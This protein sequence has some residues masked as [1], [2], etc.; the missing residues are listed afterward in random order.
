MAT[1]RG[2]KEDQRSPTAVPEHE[3]LE[4]AA[5]VGSPPTDVTFVH[6]SVRSR[7]DRG[8]L[9]PKARAIQRQTR[10]DCSTSP[11][12]NAMRFAFHAADDTHGKHP[13]APRLPVEN[14]QEPPGRPGLSAALLY[15]V[16]D[17]AI[18]GPL[19]A[20]RAKRGRRSHRFRRSGMGRGRDGPA[21]D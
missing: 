7:R 15:P 4:I 14:S 10:R 2:G 21:I 9:F 6:K 8:E 13:K 11:K 12:S 20:R 18:P 3:H 5:H 19:S 17:P 16:V 1:E